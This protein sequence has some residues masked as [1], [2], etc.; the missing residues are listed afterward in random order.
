M[1]LGRLT[2]QGV[3]TGKHA[4]F[5]FSVSTKLCNIYVLMYSFSIVIR[6]DNAKALIQSS[7]STF[8][9]VLLM[10][11]ALSPGNANC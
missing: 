8:Q 11:S 4:L 6:T 2:Q 3:F 7:N 10:K 9:F 1:M 5:I